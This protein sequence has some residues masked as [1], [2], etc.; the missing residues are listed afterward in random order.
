MFLVWYTMS[1]GALADEKNDGKKQRQ[2]AGRQKDRRKTEERQKK[3]RRKTEERQK[4]DKR[5]T[6]ER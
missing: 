3:D 6:E 1:I 5:K 2:K 4:K